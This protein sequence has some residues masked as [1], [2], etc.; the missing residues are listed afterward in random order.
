[1]V[2]WRSLQFQPYYTATAA[3]IGYGWWSHDIGGHMNGVKD[4]ELACRW[5]QFGVFSPINRLHSTCNQFA[6][7]EPWR[8]RQDIREIMGKFLQLRHRMIPYLHSMN[9][10]SHLEG[11]PLIRPMYHGWPQESE[12]YRCPNQY[13]FGSQMIVAPVITPS[14]SSLGISVTDVWLP[15]GIY[16]DFFPA[17]AIMA[18]AGPEHTDPWM[19][20]RHL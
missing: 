20:F 3:N 12:A 16:F 5:L 15:D 7:K 6:G 2:S 1:M 19:Q 4:D 10:R 13:E 14:D 17:S 18:V 11:I 9:Y 8:Y